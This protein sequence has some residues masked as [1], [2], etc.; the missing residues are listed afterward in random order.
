[1]LLNIINPMLNI[2]IKGG[3]FWI[4]AEVDTASLEVR[5][6]AILMALNP[7]A[8]PLPGVLK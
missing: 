3:L 8:P 4:D 1:M 5:Q 2:S 7:Q 6:H